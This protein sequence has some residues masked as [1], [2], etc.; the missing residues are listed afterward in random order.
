M[1]LTCRVRALDTSQMPAKLPS[2]ISWRKCVANHVWK[3][4]LTVKELTQPRG[5][6]C[7]MPKFSLVQARRCLINGVHV[8]SFSFLFRFCIVFIFS[9]FFR[10]GAHIYKRFV[11]FW[12]SG[13]DKFASSMLV[14]RGVFGVLLPGIIFTMRPLTDQYFAFLLLLLLL[15]LLRLLLSLW[16]F[17]H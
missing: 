1:S 10:F 2:G 4:T 17:T 12:F 8:F 3:M 13:H 16:Q 7:P 5:A 15:L 11:G 6:W 9:F 14:C